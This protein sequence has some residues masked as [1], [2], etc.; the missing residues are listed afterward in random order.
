MRFSS[1]AGDATKFDKIASPAR[2]KNRSC[3]RGFMG[4]QTRTNRVFVTLV[5]LRLARLHL[6]TLNAAWLVVLFTSVAI[7]QSNYFG[8]GFTTL[9]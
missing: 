5:F 8:F 3:G 4:I 9:N 2:T 6:F 1:R 7:G